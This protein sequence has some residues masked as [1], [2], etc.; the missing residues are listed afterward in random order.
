MKKTIASAIALSI[1]AAIAAPV[2]AEARTKKKRTHVQPYAAQA[3]RAP[4]SDYRYEEFIAEKR[5]TGSSS[6][7]EQMDREGRG[8]QSR[9]N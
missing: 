2:A 5:P 7:W 4:R 6:W 1:A 9:A 3:Y 8:G